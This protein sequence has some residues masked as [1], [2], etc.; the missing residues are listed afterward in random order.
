MQKEILICL[1]IILTSF[2]CDKKTKESLYYK[3]KISN[4]QSLETGNK[5]VLDTSQVGSIKSIEVPI[6]ME[7]CYGKLEITKSFKIYSN[8]EFRL[9]KNFIGSTVIRINVDK[10]KPSRLLDITRDTVIIESQ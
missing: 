6:S 10:R 5:I 4:C 3:Y 2:T 8:M 9:E 7:Y 1:L